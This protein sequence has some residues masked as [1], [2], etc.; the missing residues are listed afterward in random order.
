MDH[1]LIAI[2]LASRRFTREGTS[3]EATMRFD[4][5]VLDKERVHRAFQ[6]D[7]HLGDHALRN[8]LDHHIAKLQLLIDGGDIGLIARQAVKG[9][10][11]HNIEDIVLSIP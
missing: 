2:G 3:F 5:E 4:R 10:R 11:E 7:V 1:V 8:S 9:F 6:P